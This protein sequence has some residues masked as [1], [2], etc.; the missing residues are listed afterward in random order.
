MR[1][2]AGEMRGRQLKAVEGMRTRPTSD[3]VKGAIFNVL[4]NK[5][6]GARVLDLFA[7]TG[8]LAFEALSRGSDKAVMVEKSLAAYQVIQENL[9][10]V[11]AGYKVKLFLMDAFKYLRKNPQEVFDLVFL[12]P[13]YRQELVSKSI[14][15]LR[16]YSVLA[17]TGVIIAETAKDEQL[18]EDMYPFEIRKTSEYGDTKVWYLQ[19]MDGEGED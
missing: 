3:K 13:P 17:P 1:I 6:L 4:G 18:R 12:D 2:I 10:R 11:G 9:E 16:E 8:N 5:V 19:R 15:T 14:L 7:G